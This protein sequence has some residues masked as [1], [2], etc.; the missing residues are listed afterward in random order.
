MA[1]LTLF[2]IFY[3]F[4]FISHLDWVVLNNLTVLPSLISLYLPL[5]SFHL[6][7][8]LASVI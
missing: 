5:G 4:L 2:P 8:F 6:N 7:P 1:S 3:V